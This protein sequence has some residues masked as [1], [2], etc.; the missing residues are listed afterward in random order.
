MGAQ[1][2]LQVQLRDDTTFAN[3]VTGP[4]QAAVSHINTAL[5]Q[6]T[7]QHA[8]IYLWGESG[9]GRTHLLHAACHC[10]GEK[11][12]TS[13]Y[14][15]LAEQHTL[16]PD[17]L[18]DLDTLPLICLDDIDS[19]LG[20]LRWEEALFHLYNR[21]R[22]QQGCLMVTARQSPRGLTIT[23]PD[24]QSRLM[25]GTTFQLHNL[26]DNEKC[27]ALMLRAD[28]RGMHLSMEVAQFL[29]RRLSRDMHNLFAQLAILDE[30]SLVEK[31]RLTLPFVKSVLKV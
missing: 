7:Q 8:F 22:E 6:L 4:N 1:A 31:R 23:L 19:V 11:H 28:L 15:P 29:V 3:Y 5:S 9:M 27:D 21:V 24:L 14:L 26:S 2:T 17:V 18:T 10:C 20:D 25:W 16:T 30:A 13:A 12:H